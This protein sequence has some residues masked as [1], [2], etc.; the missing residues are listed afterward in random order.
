[1]RYYYASA[2]DPMLPGN[3]FDR[4]SQWVGSVVVAAE[5]KE[6]AT[7]K[8]VDLLPKPQGPFGILT[9]QCA[10]M[11][12]PVGWMIKPEIVNTVL[13]KEATREMLD[14]GSSEVSHDFFYA[15]DPNYVEGTTPPRQECERDMSPEALLGNFRSFP[16]LDAT[17]AYRAGNMK[18][19][20]ALFSRVD[21]AE[22]IGLR[23]KE[24]DEITCKLF[25]VA[26]GMM[27]HIL[28][29]KN[30]THSIEFTTD[31]LCIVA[32]ALTELSHKLYRQNH[33]R[34]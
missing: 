19:V 21:M 16:G 14:D 32:A 20:E 5:N 33:P 15:P 10:E 12:V 26:A 34:K 29:C 11:V 6:E 4:Y 13:D 7:T 18:K 28:G 1:M 23:P 9:L 25:D 2:I 8:M 17:K 24:D 3:E 31:S 27:I 30:K 22:A